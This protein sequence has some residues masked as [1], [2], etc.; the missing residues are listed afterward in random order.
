MIAPERIKELVSMD[1]VLDMYGIMRSRKRRIPCPLHGGENNN[2][3]YNRHVYHC[4]TCGA[5]GDVIS[6]VMA[7]ENLNYKQAVIHLQNAFKLHDNENGEIT[8]K[9]RESTAQRRIE[10]L[11]VQKTNMIAERNR[12]WDLMREFAPKSSE[13]IPNQIYFNAVTRAEQLT[14]LINET[15]MEIEDLQRGGI[16]RE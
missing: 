4:F 5:K 11:R 1:N 16:K 12:C 13:E 6:F 3:G 7:Y 15:W 14:Y 8:R 2:F 10:V 9:N